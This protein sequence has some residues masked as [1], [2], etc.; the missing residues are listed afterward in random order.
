MASDTWHGSGPD[1][2]KMAVCI[3]QLHRIEV[4][5]RDSMKQNHARNNVFRC[6]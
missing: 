4:A 3:E 2:N 1:K 6:F 5:R